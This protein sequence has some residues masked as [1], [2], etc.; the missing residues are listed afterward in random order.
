MKRIL[1]K[2]GKVA[3]VFRKGNFK[4]L[5]TAGSHWVGFYAEVLFYDLSKRFNPIVDL[6]ILLQ[7][8]ALT[9]ALDVVEVADNEL[10]FRYENGNFKEVLTPGRYAFWKG[11][12]EH[13]FVYA[14]LSKK[15]ITEDIDLRILQQ[16][17]ISP[18]LRIFVVE[19]YEKALLYSDGKLE[20]E[21]ETGVH[22]F[23][24]TPKVISMVK[25]DTRQLQT[26]VL[27][28]EILTKDKATLRTNFAL[29]YR[30]VDIKKALIETNNYIK[31]LYVLT[32]MAVREYMSA[33][34]LDEVL[35]RKEEVNVFVKKALSVQV[36]ELGLE[37]IEAG[38]KDI[39]L[40][41]DVKDIMNQVLIAQKRAQ[42]NIITRREETASTRSLLNTAKLM[43]ENEML[44]RLKEMEYTEK[45]ADK[46]NGISLS[47]GGQILDQLRDIFVPQK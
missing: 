26:E 38:I 14:D 22:Y 30:I 33:Y 15:E 17:R 18:Y 24:K 11:V 12:I 37:I 20:R 10:V 43:E 4:Q 39:I 28:Q 3:L 5:L 21:L 16:A 25:A 36:A 32:Q 23:W 9:D 2:D 8:A 42:A 31:Q 47:G 46:I 7:N 44:F 41:G 35:E 34:T 29:H 19:N 1:I 45:I 6:N 40:P 27:G 13:K